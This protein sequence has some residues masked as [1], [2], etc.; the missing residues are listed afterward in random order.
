M[1]TGR[2][3][4]RTALLAMSLLA[5]APTARAAEPIRFSGRTGPAQQT[6]LTPREPFLPTEVRDLRSRSRPELP[7]DTF[8][9]P[10][11][12]VTPTTGLTRRQLE[13]QERRRNWLLQSPEG[14]RDDAAKSQTDRA[15][16]AQDDQSDRTNPTSPNPRHL[17]GPDRINDPTGKNRN[18]G[19]G[20]PNDRE[21]NPADN[22]DANSSDD[23]IRDTRSAWEPRANTHLRGGPEAAGWFGADAIRGSGL[24]RALAEARE[25][26]RERERTASL[27]AFRRSFDNP[28]AQTTANT[29]NSATTRPTS[30]ALLAMPG[31]DPRRATAPG[32]LATSPRAATDFSPRGGG[33]FDPSNPLN[34]GSAGTV[35]RA[36][37]PA[38][39]PAPKPIVLEVPKRKF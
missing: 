34:Y 18:P 21:R 11:Q 31:S 39:R 3:N 29:A 10:S 5:A 4:L 25:R 1:H 9:L 20:R 23:K 6:L 16:E 22:R 19:P 36:P 30:P 7:S 37:E 32:A 17:E 14:L 28:W 33:A 8:M 2:V 15:R 12:S 13:D 26:E 35:F 24:S 27:D 38:A